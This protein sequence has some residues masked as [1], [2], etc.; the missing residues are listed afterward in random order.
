MGESKQAY[1]AKYDIGEGKMATIADIAKQASMSVQAIR[2]RLNRGITGAALLEPAKDRA[3]DSGNGWALF[4]RR[5]AEAEEQGLD[6]Q[7]K[8]W[9]ANGYRGRGG[10][11]ILPSGANPDWLPLYGKAK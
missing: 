1:L 10:E 9:K 3:T 8:Q 7:Q 11:M 6:E 4:K 2:Q 5:W